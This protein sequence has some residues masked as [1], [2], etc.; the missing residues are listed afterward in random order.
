MDD[1]K[2]AHDAVLAA[3][4][5]KLHTKAELINTLEEKVK[6][7]QQEHEAKVAQLNEVK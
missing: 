6:E 3:V 4:D 1:N 7:M 5:E 2:L